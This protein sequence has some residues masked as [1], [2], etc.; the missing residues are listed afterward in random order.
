M[1]RTHRKW[2]EEEDNLLLRQVRAFP[3]NLSKCFLMVAQNT[4]RTPG[5]VAN[6][7]YSVVS[8][9]PNVVCF[10]TASSKHI[11][12]NRKNGKGVKSTPNIWRKLLAIIRNL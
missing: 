1:E 4:D 5:A 8:K 9:R 7:W 3:Q 10:F 2:T 12:K 6:H 11:A